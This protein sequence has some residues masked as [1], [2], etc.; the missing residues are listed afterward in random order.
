MLPGYDGP[1]LLI[2]SFTFGDWLDLS[3]VKDLRKN[4]GFGMPREPVV[5]PP[6]VPL[7]GMVFPEAPFQ[8]G[9]HLRVVRHA[10]FLQCLN[11]TRQTGKV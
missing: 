3:F 5:E 8:L 2:K 1:T 10:D 4:H 11:C 7:R 9:Q 6:E